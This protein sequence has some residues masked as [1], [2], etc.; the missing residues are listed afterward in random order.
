MK[1]AKFNKLIILADE[2]LRN[3]NMYKNDDTIPEAYDGKTAALSVSV[4]MSDILPTLAIYYQD[5]DAKKP[6]KDCR[7]NV[8]NVVA[9][10]IDKPN[11]DAKFL[12]AEELVRYSVSGDAD[13]Q[14]IKKQVID[15]A[16]ALK[17]VVRTYKLV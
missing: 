11:E 10:M 13:L 12:D 17:H 9:T 14:Y 1:K 2:K 7:R 5:F 8:L 16:I 6:D 4:A 15:C 3:S